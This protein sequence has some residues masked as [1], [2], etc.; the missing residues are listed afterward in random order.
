MADSLGI[1]T[2]HNTMN[3]G[4]VLQAYALRQVLA[5]HGHEA[6][7]IDYR[8]SRVTRVESARR[9]GPR[10]WLRHPR[11]ALLSAR[12]YPRRQARREAFDAFMAAH[13]NLGPRVTSQAE[14]AARYGTIVAGSDQIWNLD[15]TD[16]DPTFF[17]GDVPASGCRKISYA[18][19]FGNSAAPERYGADIAAALADFSA[20]SVR[21]EGGADMVERLTGHR[22]AVTLDPTL[23]L[24]REGW[25]DIIGPRLVEGDYVFCY[26]ASD[27]ERTLAFARDVAERLGAKLVAID[28]YGIRDEEPGVTFMT[29]ASPEDFLSLV[30]HAAQVVTSSFHGMAMSLALERPFWFALN[31]AAANNNGRLTGLAA[32]LGVENRNIACGFTDEPID[33]PQVAARMAELRETSL[34]FLFSALEG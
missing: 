19:S 16:A 18:A 27:R 12:I 26:I 17:L 22:P 10:T 3:Y 23:L 11:T 15:L 1:L 9:P 8:N 28:C 29:Q 4:A 2:F 32:A 33:F 25:R 20:I 6:E 24:P 14:L 13:L 5:A 21:E 30:N 31:R 7:T 34:G